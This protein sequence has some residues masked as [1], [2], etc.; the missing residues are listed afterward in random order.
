MDA[1]L[2]LT[3]HV[4]PEL[5][6]AIV[7]GIE[8]ASEHGRHW[9][10]VDVVAPLLETEAVKSQIPPDV[11]DGARLT[12]GEQM[13]KL[14]AKGA[15]GEAGRMGFRFDLLAEPSLDFARACGADGVTPL[16]FLATC[17][18]SNQLPDAASQETQERLNAARLT[19]DVLAPARKGG[20]SA[21]A[22]MGY[23][24]HSLG[25]GFDLTAMAR[26]GFWRSC[27]VVGMERQLTQLAKMISYGSYSV[28]VVGEPGVGKS[29]LIYGLA[30]NVARRTRPLILPEMDDYVIVSIPKAHL[31]SGTAA[32]GAMDKR[33]DE[34][35]RFCA[36][37]P[38]VIPF[39]D[40]VHTLLSQE[41]ASTKTI[42]NALKEAMAMGAFRCIGVTT[43]QEYARHIASD[44]ALNRR[45]TR[46]M[47]PEPDA[48]ATV[49]IIRGSRG[50]IVEGRAERLGVALTDE[51]IRSAVRITS[52][53]Q[54]N[55]RQPA[56]S[57]GLL[58]NVIASVAYGLG[59]GRRD[60]SITSE[61][62]AR[63]FSD[64]S[65]IPV[66]YLD[67]RRDEFYARLTEDLA[68]RVHGQPEAVEAVTSWLG[69]HASGLVNPRRPRGRFLFLGP[70]GVGKTEL[71]LQLAEQVMRD[72][73]SLVV[74][75]MGEYKGEGARSKFMGA[76][77]GY[78]GF[79]QT[80]T[81]Y[82]RVFM[83]PY[84]VV[85]L[86]EFEKANPDLADVLLSVFDGQAEDSSGRSVDFSQCI[87]IMTSN[88]L[89]ERKMALLR[90]SWADLLR[91][92]GAA[93][94]EV[95][96]AANADVRSLL[97]MLGE[98]GPLLKMLRLGE[99]PIFTPPL[100]D[101]IDKIVVFRPLA[102][103]VLLKILGQMIADLR[104]GDAAALPASLDDESVRRQVLLDAKALS[105]GAASARALER[106]L[107]DY[108]QSAR[109]SARA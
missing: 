100:L 5:K 80:S 64:I 51:A 102:D 104:R 105:G 78:V 29:A 56:K 58:K 19:L 3:Q 60:P 79:R 59:D 15:R 43:D 98:G 92:K 9:H 24:Y 33:V 106:A 46:I 108:M 62:V 82:D 14:D 93:E 37:N 16:V 40:E 13:T 28:A 36:E 67:D 26:D 72:R 48:E 50:N 99:H 21:K 42:G 101:R 53:Y 87:F 89:D 34:L 96:R 86:D 70:P 35:I 11:L 95:A 68:A 90:G 20:S 65:G 44:E 54:R 45:F 49:S 83:R 41:E 32:R 88:A 8:R 69:M 75:N 2:F 12:L 4:S 66:D 73:G 6:Q 31:V 94:E 76:D 22:M 97:K 7:R 17:V 81:I 84:S 77:P 18:S 91:E 103:D 1:E 38:T 27:P 10:L 63:E 109:Q 61:D 107:Y 30:Y 25:Y 57:I 55:N 74:K 39:F 52:R 71:G 23:T 85:V 47:I